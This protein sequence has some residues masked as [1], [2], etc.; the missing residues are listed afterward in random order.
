MFWTDFHVAHVLF[1]AALIAAVMGQ[2]L[3]AALAG[4]LALPFFWRS[5]RDDRRA[6]LG[7]WQTCQLAF[8]HYLANVVFTVATILG[9]L[10]YRVILLPSSIFRPHGP[11]GTDS[12][13]PVTIEPIQ[14]IP[15]DDCGTQD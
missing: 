10:K 6:G 13:E 8:I 1:G 12:H 5:L 7:P 14:R 11:E 15:A 2:C 9:A 3:V 4:V